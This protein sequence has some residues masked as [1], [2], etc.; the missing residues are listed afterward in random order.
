MWLSIQKGRKIGHPT[1]KRTSSFIK[2]T[3]FFI[4]FAEEK[5]AL[6]NF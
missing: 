3:V 6:I 5:N 4:I 2:P 1:V